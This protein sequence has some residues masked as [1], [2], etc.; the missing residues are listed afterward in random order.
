MGSSVEQRSCEGRRPS[1][2]QAQVTMAS[3][4]V[5]LPLV[6]LTLDTEV[7]GHMQVA[8]LDDEAGKCGWGC[9]REVRR[10]LEARRVSLSYVHG[11]QLELH[12]TRVP[13][14]L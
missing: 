3:V 11:G 8:Y 12:P 5:S 4:G 14:G 6:S 1:P 2:G 13:W 10:E 9:G 7:R